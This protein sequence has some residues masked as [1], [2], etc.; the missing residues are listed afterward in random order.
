[1]GSEECEDCHDDVAEYTLAPT[2]HGDCESCHG[3]GDLHTE[4]EET[5]DIRFPSNADCASCHETGRSSH[6]GWTTSEHDRA[7]VLCSD[8]HAPHNREPQHLRAPVAARGALLRNAGGTTRLCASC[9]AE[10]ASRLDLPSHHPIRE[11]M[12]DCTDCHQPHQSRRVMLG[13]RTALCTGCHQEQAGPWIY[14]HTPVAED[15]ATCHTAHGSAAYDLL[16]TS[17]PGV[18]ITCHTLPTMGAPHDPAAFVTRCT[19]C[20]GAIHGSYEDP[21]LRR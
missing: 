9:H 8:C 19:D 1:M 21:H 5:A 11:G 17:Q 20:H 13:A 7:G 6:V 16:E 14:E 4:S 15:C 2:Y 12:L 10:V 18:C 3:F